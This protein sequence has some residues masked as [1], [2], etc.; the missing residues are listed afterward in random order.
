VRT[1]DAFD[2]IRATH[3]ALAAADRVL[4]VGAGPVGIELAGEIRSV[5]ADKSVVLLDAQGELLGGRFSP[6]LR[7][8]LTS[9]LS[10]F[11]IEVLLGSPLSESPPT[12]PGELGSFTVTTRAGLVLTADIWF[13]CYG[14][15]PNS[16][17]LAGPLVGARRADGFIEVDANLRVVGQSSVFALGDLSTADAKMAGSAG[18]Q[19]AVV[20][21]NVTALIAGYDEL[22]T[23]EPMGPGIVIPIGPEAGAGQ[24]SGR[25]GIVDRST[26]S[27]LKGRDLMVDR[28]SELL[29]L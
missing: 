3:D 22:A 26:V 9:Q 21:A 2:Q 28:F 4:L 11:R 18:R 23:Y 13:R 14:V 6:E 15:V 16:D 19:A 12:E 24:F 20:A 25:E 17:L 29:N 7:A 27:E 8:E 1:E 10:E 5:W